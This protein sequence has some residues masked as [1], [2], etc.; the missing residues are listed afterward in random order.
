M[1]HAFA[2]GGRP[3][4]QAHRTSPSKGPSIATIRPK[5]STGQCLKVWGHHRHSFHRHIP[6]LSDSRG[7]WARPSDSL[8]RSAH[9]L[10]CC[11]ALGTS[12]SQS[13]RPSRNFKHHCEHD[14]ADPTGTGSNASSGLSAIRER[15]SQAQKLRRLRLELWSWDSS[16]HRLVP[17]THS[18]AIARC[19]PVSPVESRHMR[20]FQASA[21]NSPLST[22]SQSLGIP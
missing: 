19:R 13:K 6:R 3:P 8:E 1:A 2:G 16:R 14:D 22:G 12:S 20:L 17:Q 4:H 7:S 11:S 10:L 5:L 15:Q 9:S 18:G 21:D